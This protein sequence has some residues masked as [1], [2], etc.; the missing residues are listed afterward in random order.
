MPRERE[1]LHHTVEDCGTEP[2]SLGSGGRDRRHEPLGKGLMSIASRRVG[3]AVASTLLATIALAPAAI[4]DVGASPTTSPSASPTPSAGPASPT[5]GVTATSTSSPTPAPSTASPTPTVSSTPSASVHLAA[6]AVSGTTATQAENAAAFIAATLAAGGD[7]YVY[8]GTTYFDG[9]NTIDA[10]L[11]LDGAGVGQSEAAAATDYLAAHLG[12]YIGTGG[13]TY[14]GPTAKALLAFVAQGWDPHQV[15]GT[16]LVSTLAGLET[17]SGRFSDHSAFGDYSN[18]IGQALAIIALARAGGTVSTQAVSFLLA[19]QCSD[20]GFRNDLAVQGCTSDP[21]ATAFAVQALLTVASS[22]P[23]T[24]G[25]AAAGLDY[26]VARQ[27]ADGGI[28]SAQSPE[29]A[30][31][32]GVAAQAFAAG[33]RASALSEAQGFIAGL[34]YDCTY[35]APLRGGIAFTAADRAG[36]G[37]TTPAD[38]DLRATPQAALGLAGGTLAWVSGVENSP[39]TTA[40]VCAAPTASTSTSPGA[41]AQPTVTPTVADAG[42]LAYTGAPVLTPVLL[43]LALLGTGAALLVT[44]SLVRRRG[45]HR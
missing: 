9:G 42:S 24:A 11:A 28:A 23:P 44:G 14:A 1:R 12:D 34:Q 16:D 35:Q 8:P 38:S 3:A 21:D 37:T 6:P 25:A 19:Q 40:M 17:S 2:G 10:I 32:T 18:T 4:A 13:E 15:G 45:A 26:L 36:T 39:G 43:A 41:T 22:T 27:G 29:N 20:G 30:N 7:H 31:T 33:G 5:P